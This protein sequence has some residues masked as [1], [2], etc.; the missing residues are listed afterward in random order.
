[1][2]SISPSGLCMYNAWVG[3]KRRRFD[4]DDSDT[5]KR[6]QCQTAPTLVAVKKRQT[7]SPPENNDHHG[8]LSD[9]ARKRI[10]NAC[11]WMLFLSADKKIYRRAER[12]W[13][14]FR[15]C[16][17]TLTLPSAQQH[18]DRQIKHDLLYQFLDEMRKSYDVNHYVW[19]AEKQSNGNIHFH[20]ILNKFIPHDQLRIKWNRICDKL[21]YTTRYQKRM[22]ETIRSFADYHRLFKAQGSYKQLLR[23]YHVGLATGWRN[24]NTIDIHSVVKIRNLSAY[25]CK[26]LAKNLKTEYE[27]PEDIPRHLIVEGR[28]WGLSQ[29][30][31]KLKNV[32]TE[33]TRAIS[34]EIDRVAAWAGDRMFVHE[35]FTWIRVDFR[36][37]LRLNCSAIMEHVYLQMARLNEHI[38]NF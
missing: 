7:P 28:L 23:R 10:E 20:I 19:R 4:D 34:A 8:V 6:N 9:K 26:Y 3:P 14:K 1:M 32:T 25:L 17:V 22:R 31:S 15:L 11:K 18:P 16:F 24:P 38:I 27:R 36:Q 21:G 13:I 33:V 5:P 29:S 37:L 35:Y 30:L 2:V 12:R